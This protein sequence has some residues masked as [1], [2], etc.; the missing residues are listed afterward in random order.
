MIPTTSPQQPERDRVPPPPPVCRWTS[1]E[2]LQGQREA[3]IDHEGRIYRLRLT[4]S[5][6]LLLQK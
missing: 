3:L 5:G 1:T 4:K 2:L 6:K